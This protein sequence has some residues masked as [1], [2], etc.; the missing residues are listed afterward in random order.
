MIKIVIFHVN[1]FPVR[2][3]T[4]GENKHSTQKGKIQKQIGYMVKLYRV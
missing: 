2:S 1:V 3:S 4:P